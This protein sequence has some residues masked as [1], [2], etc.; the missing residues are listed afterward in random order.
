MPTLK[1]ETITPAQARELLNS[2]YKNRKLS[3]MKIL[4]YAQLMLSNKWSPTASKIDIDEKGKLINGN[5]RLEAIIL[6]N[7]PV[8]M[9]VHR[10][11]PTSDREVIDTGVKRSLGQLFSMYTNRKNAV[12]Y[13]AYINKCVELST[14]GAYRIPLVQTLDSAKR[15]ESVF[16]DGLDWAMDTFFTGKDKN[17]VSGFMQ[18]A[19][20][21]GTFAF[22]F[23]RNPAKVREFAKMVVDG[24]N[25]KARTP[26]H[27]VRTM[28]LNMVLKERGGRK[29]WKARDVSLKILSGLCAHIKD[30]PYAT[31]QIS[32][33]ARDYFIEAYDTAQVKN[34]MEPFLK[35]TYEREAAAAKLADA[36]K[37]K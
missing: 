14:K 26:A 33:E 28:L 27:T 7:T 13:A 4:E 37:V 12:S 30:T 29:L 32:K 1:E 3:Q 36:A 16:G 11:V 5:H 22:A 34:I 23:K 25:L 35:L 24:E 8:T 31:A 10:G 18:N 6:T 2:G 15:W 9:L 17:G 21:G 19:Y 20:I